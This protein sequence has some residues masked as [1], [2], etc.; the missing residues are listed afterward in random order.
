MIESVCSTV[1]G[2][3]QAVYNVNEDD[4]LVTNFSLNVVGTTPLL[5]L[6]V[7]G[8]I[9]AEAAGTASKQHPPYLEWCPYSHS[10]PLSVGSSDFATLPQITVINNNADPATEISVFAV[11]D[12]VTLEYDDRVFLR[13]TPAIPDL[14]PGLESY[15]ESI[16][17]TAIVNIIDS[18]C[19]CVHLSS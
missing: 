16:R 8:T 7:S 2:F 13:F 4:I 1:H 14:I 17:D 12:K 6:V 19:K 3:P 15:F 9:T 11:N 10:I 5:G 18:D